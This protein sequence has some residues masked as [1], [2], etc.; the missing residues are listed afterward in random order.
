ML[1]A[2]SASAQVVALTPLAP[3]QQ[4]QVESVLSCDE[5]IGIGSSAP[6][7]TACASQPGWDDDNIVWGTTWDE[8]DNIV[9]GTMWD[10]AD[11]IVWGTMWDEADNIVWG[12]ANAASF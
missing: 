10:E 5:A 2:S 9:W 4:V 6:R 3:L 1:S 7:S 8:A 11:N 12:T